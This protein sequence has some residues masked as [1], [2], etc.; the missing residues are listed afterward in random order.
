[1]QKESFLERFSRDIDEGN[2]AIFAG[3][4]ISVAAGFVNWK[5]LLSGI[6]NDLGLDVE[7]EAD[8]I[9][10]AQFHVNRHGGNRGHLNQ[11]ILEEFPT[12][13]EPTTP[14][15]FIAKLPI[16]TIWTTNYDHLL[17][18]ALGP[19]DKLDSQARQN[20]I[21]DSFCG[22]YLGAFADGGCRVGIL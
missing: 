5:S 8:L 1:M 14:Q 19:V 9:G 15:R 11:L 4:G 10:V 13:K 16:G 17:E 22:G 12:A 21:Q 20:L 18:R 7:R 6:A 2:A 3:A